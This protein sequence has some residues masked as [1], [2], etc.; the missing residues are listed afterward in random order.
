MHPPCP[1]SLRLKRPRLAKKGLALACVTPK[2]VSLW[3]L[4]RACATRAPCGLS[5]PRHDTLPQAHPLMPALGFDWNA[6][7]H[8]HACMYACMVWEGNIEGTPPHRAHTHAHVVQHRTGI[9]EARNL[10][11]LG[12][13]RPTDARKSLRNLSRE[14]FSSNLGVCPEA[15]CSGSNSRAILEHFVVAFADQ[16]PEL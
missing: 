7:R 8:M 15:K 3:S 11:K 5:P 13:S 2:K 12:R 10:A 6:R 9:S 16:V 4:G 14:S 1:A